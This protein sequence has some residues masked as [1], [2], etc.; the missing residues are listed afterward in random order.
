MDDKVFEWLHSEITGYEKI[1]LSSSVQVWPSRNY[2]KNVM[3]DMSSV[4][5]RLDGKDNDLMTQ[6]FLVEADFLFLCEKMTL[7]M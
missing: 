2:I 7:E 6:T 3:I 1:R 4:V 5:R